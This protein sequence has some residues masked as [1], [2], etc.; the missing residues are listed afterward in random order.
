MNAIKPLA[1]AVLLAVALPP[2]AS[3]QQSRSFTIGVRGGLNLSDLSGDVNF[4][5]RVG[6]GFGM[7]GGLQLS[8]LWSV[9]PELSYQQKGAK[10]IAIQVP[11]TERT[12]KMSYLELQVPLVLYPEVGDNP[13]TPRLYGGPYGSLQLTCTKEIEDPA[14]GSASSSDC[15]EGS[16][17]EVV[18]FGKSLD[19]GFL[20][21]AG[22][23]LGG[24]DRG[25]FTLD[26]RYSFGLAN[27]NE[28]QLG[29]DVNHRVIQLLVG[30][31][32][33]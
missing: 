16:P 13:F 27:I 17:G 18:P 8:E 32:H 11:V 3:A 21:G 33:R 6:F 20:I 31:A 12:I 7:F 30:Y 29:G 1:V 22:V 28:A 23:N 9:F 19:F 10:D 14:G 4:D 24:A 2:I 25:G 5:S 15:E 26:V